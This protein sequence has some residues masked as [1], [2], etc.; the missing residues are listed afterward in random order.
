MPVDGLQ[1]GSDL[2]GT[3]GDYESPFELEG[4]TDRVVVK[5]GQ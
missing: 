2:K 4:K 5:V 3:V 1:I